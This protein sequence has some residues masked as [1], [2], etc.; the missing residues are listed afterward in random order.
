MSDMKL[1]ESR[2]EGLYCAQGDFYI[3]P[4]RPVE[5]AV[6]THAHA[7]HFCSGCDSYFGHR[8]TIHFLK[9]RMGRIAPMHGFEYNSSFEFNGVKLSLHSAGHM[10]GSAQVRIEY[11][12][13]VWVVTGDLKP[14][15]NPYCEPFEQLTCDFLITECTF[16]D[17]V[18]KWPNEQEEVSKIKNW[19]QEC[20]EKELHPVLS[21]YA[22]GKAQKTQQLLDGKGIPILVHPTIAKFNE[23]YRE[24]GF[25]IPDF[26]I[27]K[28]GMSKK[29]IGN[30]LVLVPPSVFNTAWMLRF[31]KYSAGLSSGWVLKPN[32]V[33]DRGADCGFVLSDHADFDGLVK[34]IKQS[35]V[36]GV[37]LMHGDK[38]LMLQ[39][40]Q[41]LELDIKI[42]R[43]Q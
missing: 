4:L 38:S 12:G 7:D 26:R 35:K 6:I 36:K 21:A 34:N 2:A 15:N 17:P 3:D 28:D 1:I 23:S 33:K 10:P 13:E 16:S 18:F 43:Y 22:I 20:I 39:N 9:L 41:N 11:A 8:H 5:R 32:T 30:A 31:E 40:L 19:Y 37:Y 25:K 14:G 29:K 24:L 27:L 42:L